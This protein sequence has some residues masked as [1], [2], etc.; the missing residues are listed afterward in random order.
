MGEYTEECINTFLII[1]CQIFDEPGR[2]AA[3]IEE[4]MVW[5]ADHGAVISQNSWT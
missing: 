1:M 2:D 4:I 3:T 5:T